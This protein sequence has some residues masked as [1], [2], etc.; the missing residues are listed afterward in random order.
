MLTSNGKEYPEKLAEL[1]EETDDL[2]C[3]V[4]FALTAGQAR[5]M[6][7]RPAFCS[8]AHPPRSS[9]SMPYD[10]DRRLNVTLDSPLV[11]EALQ[12][13]GQAPGWVTPG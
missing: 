13:G 7:R 12:S 6:L 8:M 5:P 10:A 4:R 2:G 9:L 11:L 1:C 3:P